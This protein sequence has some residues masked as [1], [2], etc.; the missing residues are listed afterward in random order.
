[1]LYRRNPHVFQL[2]QE[3]RYRNPKVE[4]SRFDL[5]VYT[6]QNK[7]ESIN[8]TNKTKHTSSIC[9][10]HFIVLGIPMGSL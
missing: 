9:N 1:M 5:W 4:R 8:Q 7:H 10:T 2:H 6:Y 3:E